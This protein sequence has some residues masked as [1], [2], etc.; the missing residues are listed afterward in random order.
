[1]DYYEGV[2]EVAKLSF[3]A[4]DGPEAELAAAKYSFVASQLGYASFDS[5]ARD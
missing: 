5:Q 3:A 4:L 1:V 2:I